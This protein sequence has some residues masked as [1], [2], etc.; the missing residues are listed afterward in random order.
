M[1]GTGEHHLKL[2]RFRR[3]KAACF[4]SHSIALTQIQQCYEKQVIEGKD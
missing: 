1:D 3:P 2:A 4:P